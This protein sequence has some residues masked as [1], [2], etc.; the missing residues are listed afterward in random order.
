MDKIKTLFGKNSIRGFLAIFWSFTAAIYIFAVT[1]YQVPESNI[2][3]ADLVIGFLLGTVVGTIMTY[4]LG[5]S[6]SSAEKND[7]LANSNDTN[8]NEKTST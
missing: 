5:S 3:F 8:T 4:F 1:F 7:L 6:Q 2:R